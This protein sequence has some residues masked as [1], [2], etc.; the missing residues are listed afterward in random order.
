MNKSFSQ[1]ARHTLDGAIWVTLCEAL[2]L[3]TGFLIVV[4]LTRKLGPTGYGLYTLAAV[5]VMWIESGIGSLFSPTTIKLVS[6]AEHWKPIAAS[7]TQAYFVTG[8]AVTCL[9]WLLATPIAS[10]IGEPLM[11][12]YLRL[13]AIDIPLVTLV[14]AHKSILVG[15]GGF[16]QRA[17]TSAGRITARLMLIVLLV[18]L[19]LSVTG[20]ILG[21][22]GAS[23][24][25]L[26]ICRYYI[27]PA[28]FSSSR[29]PVRRFT[30]YAVP[31]F[32]FSMSIHISDKLDLFALMAMGSTAAVA[33][34]YGA[35]Q[36]LS[37]VPPGILAMSFSPLLLSTLNRLVSAREERSAKDM[38]CQSMRAIIA[39][40]PFGAMVAGA[41]SEITDLIFGPAYSPAAPLLAT[42]IF[43]ALA[44]VFISISAA[45][46][47]A[48][49]K[50]GWAFALAGPLIPLALLGYLAVIPRF[51]AIGASLVTTLCA[52][53]GALASVFAV[54]R[55]WRIL[56]PAK[57]LLRSLLVSGVVYAMA[58]FWPASGIFLP[59]KLSAIVLTVLLSYVLLGEL[60]AREMEL[61]RALVLPKAKPGQEREKVERSRE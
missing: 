47:T 45:I 25:E 37:T 10:L 58:A 19:G 28:L 17:L 18:E 13:F 16:R 14:L 31:L 7:L 53:M 55:M 29:F 32:L 39:L 6:E 15:I 60:S 38:G 50:P 33:G 56:P 42:L 23:L 20:A 1:A 9:F 61:I 57:T 4:F 51:G 35:A 24:V 36:N 30:E 27:R 41:A 3:P 2:A 8:C 43:G 48:G 11:A 54:H 44:L 34:I 26:A 21:N 5:S 49:G 52:V 40:L 46:L 59:L 22:I 12:D